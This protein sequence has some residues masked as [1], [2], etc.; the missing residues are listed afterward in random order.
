MRQ[1]GNRLLRT[2]YVVLGDGQSEQYYLKHLKK[3]KNYKYAIRP[4][5]FASLTIESAEVIIDE[6]LSGGCDQI[7]YF[8]DYDTIVSQGKQQQFADF[9]NK[10]GSRSEVFICESMPSIEFW[11]LL[12]FLKTTREFR[13][14]DEV[15]CELVKFIKG[16]S[17][18]K[19]FLEKEKWVVELCKNGKL[20]TAVNNASSILKQRENDPTGEYFPFTKA[21][22]AIQK[23]NEQIK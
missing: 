22:L 3:L 13:N 5:L 2:N 9:K 17:K 8:T 11:F 6:L 10:Y 1:T 4:S 15:L 12:H 14:A 21:H 16:F 19:I 23:F 18:E 7:I 20:E